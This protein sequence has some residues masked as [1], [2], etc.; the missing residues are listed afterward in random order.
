[1]EESMTD[2][3]LGMFG[4]TS[5]NSLDEIMHKSDDGD[6]DYSYL[7]QSSSYYDLATIKEFCERNRSNFSVFS[8]NIQSI[9]TKIDKL[10][11]VLKYLYEECKFSFSAICIQ[12]SGLGIN[13]SKDLIQIPSY[14]LYDKPKSIGQK[15]GLLIYLH[16]DFKGT[17]QDVFKPA[18]S[19]LWEAQSILVSEGGLKQKLRIN[20]VYR[21]PRLNNSNPSIE[22]F[23]SEM[24]PYIEKLSQEPFDQMFT[25]DFNLD[26]KQINSR[27]KI[28]DYFDK[29]VSAGFLPKITLPTR[30][31]KKNCTIIDQIFCKYKDPTTENESG[32]LVTEIS[33]HLPCITSYE[34]PPK[35]KKRAK[36]IKITDRSEKNT[37]IFL[38]KLATG[39]SV[40][41]FNAD[42][43]CEPNENFNT[44]EQ[45][46]TKTMSQCFPVK[47]IRFNKY[48]HK[49]SPWMT[50]GILKSIHRRDNIYK[51][52]KKLDCNS[53]AY[54]DTKKELS[55]LNSILQRL[56]RQS[57]RDFF[58]A[59]FLKFSGD[60][61][62]TW[63]TISD[64]LSK[65][66]RHTAF[67]SHFNHE[68]FYTKE[69]DGI[70]TKQSVMLKITNKQTIADQFNVFFSTIGSNL[71]DEIKYRGTKKVSDF[72]K[73]KINSKF[74][75]HT[76]TDDYI[77]SIINK[78]KAKNS[79]GHDN[80]SSK[81]LK[82]M[83]PIIH[84]ILCLIINQSINTGIFPDSLKLAIV[85]PLFK[86]KDSENFFGNYRPISLLTTISKIFERVIFNQLYDYMTT[87]NL[88][89]NSQ[90]GFRKKH[91]TELAALEF[92]DRIAKDMDKNKV[93]L[94]IFID[95]SKAFDTLDHTILIEKL[96]YYGVE[97]SA[98]CWFQS[99]L[100]NRKQ[101]VDYNGIMSIT[102]D[103][104][105]GVPQGSILGPL[106]F[107]IYI[108]DIVVATTVFTE[109]LFADDTSLISSL[110]NFFVNIP[111]TNID[112]EGVNK[113]INDELQKLTE[114]LQINKLS[115]NVG[116]TKYMLFQKKR[117][118]KMYDWLK[119]E[120]NGTAISKVDTFNFLGL[121]LNSHLDW[122]DHI[123][124]I[125]NKI[126]ST[127]GVL[128]KLKNIIPLIA[129][130]LIYS[131][132][133]LPRL[134]YCNLIWGFKPT[135]LIKLQKRAV[136]IISKAKYNAHTEPLFKSNKLLTIEDIHTSK[137]L[138]FYY[139]FENNNL[140]SYFWIYMFRANSQNRTR[141]Q[142]PSQPL[143]AKTTT[144]SSTIRFS[145]PHL[146]KNTP[147]L[148]KAKAHTHSYDGFKLYVK[149]FLLN[150]YRENCTKSECFTCRRRQPN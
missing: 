32:I 24:Q 79:S 9:N 85:K 143:I 115:L 150:R 69:I 17:E 41:Q 106:L 91:S 93:P 73:N 94:S 39:I 8:L 118:N 10:K 101:K 19:K 95:L 38:N 148:I 49:I 11:C 133:I 46:M 83:A 36:F 110:C 58:H 27:E 114:W 47:R 12:E 48:K 123:N 53:N 45:Y 13:D 61:K 87:N 18:P 119:L 14:K 63:N 130:K 124:T 37:N 120:I 7:Y 102:L 88:F 109:I 103:L 55:E 132:L 99:Y 44:L 33:D 98:L 50:N 107:I 134:Y 54:I 108:N 89:L 80:I 75:L 43:Y 144:F 5:T 74:L 90:Y 66:Q 30:F 117:S 112:F 34:I 4:G 142:D 131:S 70:K 135:R 82:L 92:V 125:S 42:L 146:L 78:M 67:P 35:C 22:T 71:S 128:N 122:K 113:A 145:L 127:I 116:K 57:K 140:P 51:K 72:L 111:K 136:R 139:H 147:P 86:N 1:M 104:K 100:S 84:S 137:K 60:C 149:K 68:V 23:V 77:L 28:Q 21:P 76:V 96:K 97:G 40:T 15:S 62:K 26:L 64:I 65:K 138:C 81:L 6:D 20:N 59:E 126:S 56:M 52:L 121:T 3:M 2:E 16:E 31:S 25:G 141:N 129:M 105:T 29:F